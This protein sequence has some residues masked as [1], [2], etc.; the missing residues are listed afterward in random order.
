MRNCQLILL[1]FKLTEEKGF[2]SIKIISVPV[3]YVLNIFATSDN[4]QR[5]N[6]KYLAVTKE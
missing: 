5:K 3:F 1:T 6:N 2:H 4:L